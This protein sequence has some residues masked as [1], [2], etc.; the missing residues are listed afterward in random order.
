MAHKSVR[1]KIAPPDSEKEDMI[2]ERTVLNV[3]AMGCLFALVVCLF[4]R[5]VKF[6]F[7]DYDD[8]GYVQKNIHVQNG[9]TLADMTWAWTTTR[10]G[11]WHPLMWWSYQLDSQLFGH[12]PWAYHFANVF[13]H[14]VGTCVLFLALHRLGVTASVALWTSAIY[15]IHPLHVESVAWISERKGILSTLFL[16][17]A[18]AC[19][20]E[21]ARA[22]VRRW[23]L[24]GVGFA[25]VLGLMVKPMMVTLP[26]LLILLDAWPLRRLDLNRI[27][28]G[29]IQRLLIEKLPFLVV[30]VAFSVLAI[31][32]Q[33]SAGAVSSTYEIPVL[34]R[35]IGIPAIYLFTLLR[36]A[37]PTD[38]SFFYLPPARVVLWSASGTILIA[39]VTATLWMRRRILAPALVGWFWFLIAMLPLSGIVP[40]GMQWTADRYTD[41]PMIGIYLAVATM[42]PMIVQSNRWPTP[43]RQTRH[44]G[45]ERLLFSLAVVSL[46][47]LGSM[48][49][50]RLN[51][52][53]NSETL[54]DATLDHDP[55]NHAALSLKATRLINEGQYSSAYEVVQV[56]LVANEYNPT[57][58]GNY[59]YVL[60][61]LGRRDEAIQVWEQLLEANPIDSLTL[62]HLG[63]AYQESD[64]SRALECYRKSLAIDE[65]SSETHNNLGILLARS[66]DPSAE[67]HYLRA[68]EIWPENLNAHCNLA[69]LSLQRGHTK[70]A[71]DRYRLVLELDPRNRIA[72]NN[73]D[74]LLQS[75]AN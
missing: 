69:Y 2:T 36:A 47:V 7:V 26:I 35:L 13:Y 19:Y 21:Y 52:W 10:N 66:G 68:I 30:S 42:L 8:P 70:E 31:Y 23:W 64:P 24:A 51:A 15:S 28:L 17:V 48:S 46:I 74:V 57:L 55:T 65:E 67:G 27:E 62:L 41:I 40:L 60:N 71:I 14:A 43:E 5:A 34:D 75:D 37:I 38:L 33:S 53:R 63:N 12:T 54:V 6:D 25:M 72:S 73:L 56:G 11:N 50:V 20:A 44:L 29:C 1:K 16:F 39:G 59:A 58:L 22:N 49:H 45:R 61:K 4:G 9:L 32:A 3:F 18:L